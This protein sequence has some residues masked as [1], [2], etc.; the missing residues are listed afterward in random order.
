[1]KLRLLTTCLLIS[2]LSFGWIGCPSGGNQEEEQTEKEQKGEQ[3]GKKVPKIELST[4]AFKNGKSIPE[5]FS[6]EGEDISPKLKWSKVPEKTK[7]FVLIVDD[8]DAP[9]I[10]WVHWVLFD[11]PAS[12]RSLPRNITPDNLA[13]DYPNAKHGTNNFDQ[14][15]YG[16]PCPPKGHGKHTY[17]FRLYAVDKKLELEEGVTKAKVRRAMKGHIVGIGTLKGTYERAQESS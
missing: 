4:P 9:E 1:M 15:K 16:G 3:Q 14:L 17:H 10:T 6:C 7:S 2:F 13:D 12:A 11:L 5:K 8:P